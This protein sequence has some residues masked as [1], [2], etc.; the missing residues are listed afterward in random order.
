MPGKKTTLLMP[1][2]VPGQLWGKSAHKMLGTKAVWKRQIRGDTLSGAN[3]CC[4]VCKSIEGRMTCHEKWG[5]DDKRSIATLLGFEIHCS[6]CDLVVHAGRA[7]KLGYGG[8]V[9]SHLVCCESGRN[10]GVA[11]RRKGRTHLRPGANPEPA[12]ENGHRPSFVTPW[13]IGGTKPECSRS[14]IRASP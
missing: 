3:N 5:Y 2:L 6:N 1:E 13:R 12:A 10:D 14:A 11:L 8:V 7:F 9:I 4:S